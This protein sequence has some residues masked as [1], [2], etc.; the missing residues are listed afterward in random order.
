MP[1]LLPIAFAHRL[2]ERDA[3]VFNGVMLIDVEIAG[4]F[5]LQI[6]AAVPRDQIE[7][8]IEKANAGVVLVVA[9]AVERQRDLDLRF[10]GPPI[11][12][13]PAAP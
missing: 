4:G 7:H 1:R 10:L 13:A 9:L 3:G 11:D 12:H 2:A 5:H 6:E 8:V